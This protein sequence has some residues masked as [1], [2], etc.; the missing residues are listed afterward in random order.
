MPSCSFRLKSRNDSQR[1]EP[2]PW[3]ELKWRKMSCDSDNDLER[4]RDLHWRGQSIDSL[5]QIVNMSSSVLQPGTVNVSSS[6]K[7][8]QISGSHLIIFN[9]RKRF[10]N[11]SDKSCFLVIHF[12][13]LLTGPSM[14]GITSP[15]VDLSKSPFQLLIFTHLPLLVSMC[16]TERT[17]QHTFKHILLRLEP[18]A[19]NWPHRIPL[20]FC[21]EMTKP[22]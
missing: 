13:P 11:L 3:F 1:R 21:T 20:F 4:E 7:L 9:V 22:S 17:P 18:S 14:L 19:S 10:N 5:I 16:K 2:L 8:V 12:L 6:I 15:L